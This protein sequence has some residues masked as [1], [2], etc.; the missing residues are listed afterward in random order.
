MAQDDLLECL[1]PEQNKK[2]FNSNYRNNKSR[3]CYT[4]AQ[5]HVRVIYEKYLLIVNMQ[6]RNQ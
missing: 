5:K 1:V 3:L 2:C 4:G 6:K